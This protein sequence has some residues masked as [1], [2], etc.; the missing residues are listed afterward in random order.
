MSE[1]FTFGTSKIEKKFAL[2]PRYIDTW[3]PQGTKAI[4]WLKSYYVKTE[5]C[6]CNNENP[7]QKYCMHLGWFSYEFWHN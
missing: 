3:R 5:R 7:I 6:P 1:I 4:I 2:I